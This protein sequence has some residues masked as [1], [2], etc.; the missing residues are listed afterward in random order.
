MKIKIQ[1]EK[2][3]KFPCDL[4]VLKWV[5]GQK[6]DGSTGAVDSVLG[7]RIKKA[8][9][10]E[11]FTGNEGECLMVQT[12]GKIK[13][14]KIMVLGL[15]EQ[16]NVTPDLVRRS[17]AVIVQAARK[18][19]AKTVATI[20]I[21]TGTAAIDPYT[22]TKAMAEGALLGGYQFLKYKSKD[23]QK[24]AA[25][26]QEF[27]MVTTG[28]HERA[29]GTF[30]EKI[31]QSLAGLR[32]GE[33]TALST[34]LARD[35]VNEP[36][37]AMMPKDLAIVAKQIAEESNGFITATILRQKEIEALG[38]GAYLAVAKGS[39]EEPHFIHLVYR[40]KTV[41][42]KLLKKL[43]IIGKGITF[44]S[45]GLSL[46]PS[47]AMETMKCD[48]AGCAAVL[49]VFSALA[50]LQPNIEVHGISPVC[51]NMPSGKAAR[52]GDIVR[53]MS[54]KT[55][56]IMNTD[57]EGR[58]A[59]ADALTYVQEKIKPDAMVD[60]ATLTGACVVALG[61]IYAGYMGNNRAL[62][63]GIKKAGE[64]AGERIW[65]LP[66]PSEYR[67][68]LKGR[69]ADL[70]NVPGGRWGGAITAGLFL[71]AFVNKTP[72]VHMDIAGP[73]FEE[74]QTIS[75]MPN[76]G[77]GFGVRTMLEFIEQFSE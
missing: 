44:D 58:L 36:A 25:F 52:P 40:P 3:E 55:V 75:Y 42:K 21:G 17:A 62:L 56:E 26:P 76:G 8:I 41:G 22:A 63:E 70:T 59:L 1:E 43:A 60:L 10:E 6:M 57:A 2:L 66:L 24:N 32:A 7:G 46:K 31:K 39:D 48:M 74:K 20:I 54:G 47:N 69:V 53:T 27:V 28:V 71:E 14:K 51:E 72:W 12:M 5:K 67:D 18:H 34:I 16:S 38:M 50:K 11:G 77:T 9:Q 19:R 29:K 15:G 65:E 45:G 73:A 64:K 13:A 23:A 68:Q 37:S 35:L 61:E 49:G 4:L 30:E 33:K